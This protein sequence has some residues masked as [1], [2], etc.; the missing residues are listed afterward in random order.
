LLLFFFVFGLLLSLCL[1]GVLGLVRIL[2]RA[3]LLLFLRLVRI[4][5][6]TLLLVLLLLW[7][8]GVLRLIRVLLLLLFVELVHDVLYYQPG[9]LNILRRLL[10]FRFDIK[11]ASPGIYRS[12]QI[13]DCFL[14]IRVSLF[15]TLLKM[16][17]AEIVFGLGDQP[18][19]FA[20]GGNFSVQVH[21]LAQ[22]IESVIAVCLVEFRS[23]GLGTGY[24]GLVVLVDRLVE[25]T[26]HVQLIALRRSNS[27]RIGVNA[28]RQGQDQQHLKYHFMFS[29]VHL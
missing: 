11:R 8:I 12:L 1:V 15:G 24:E 9:H 4:L 21:R 29:C 22:I 20:L 28:L 6:R 3:L 27:G 16:G 14:Q 2:R 13:V 7:L 19:I 10:V 18:H 17:I 5:L 23:Q 26:L 25:I